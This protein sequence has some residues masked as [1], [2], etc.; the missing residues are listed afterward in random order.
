[1]VNFVYQKIT[2]KVS[3]LIIA[4]NVFMTAAPWEQYPLT[5]SKTKNVINA[6]WSIPHVGVN[7]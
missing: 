6:V 1:M 3:N 4:V 7:I 2:I 5:L